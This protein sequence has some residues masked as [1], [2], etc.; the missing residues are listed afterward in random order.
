[1]AI[2]EF[3]SPEALFGGKVSAERL[4]QLAGPS[5]M[6]MDD[7]F[8]NGGRDVLDTEKDAPQAAPP[9]AIESAPLAGIVGGVFGNQGD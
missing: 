2:Q 9:P 3:E 6:S 8:L 1:M 5:W 7:S 4:N